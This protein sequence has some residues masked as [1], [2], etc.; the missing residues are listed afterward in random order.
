MSRKRPLTRNQL[1]EFLPNHEAIK[2]FERIMDE[3]YDLLPT[4]V[5]AI[6]QA[7]FFACLALN[8]SRLVL[9]ASDSPSRFGEPETPC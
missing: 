7:I 8:D 3:V 6:N 1:A 9:S 5:I 4:D 2:A